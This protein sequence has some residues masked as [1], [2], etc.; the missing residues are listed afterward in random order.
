MCA[1][2]SGGVLVSHCPPDGSSLWGGRRHPVV[3]GTGSPAGWW[4]APPL[5]AAAAAAD[6]AGANS[7]AAA[8]LS[9]PPRGFFFLSFSFSLS[10]GCF[11]A[12]RSL[13]SLVG[14]CFCR[15]GHT[16]RGAE[17]A[18]LPES[19]QRRCRLAA[20]PDRRRCAHADARGGVQLPGRGGGATYVF[21][22]V[23]GCPR[24]PRWALLFRLAATRGGPTSPDWLVT[25]CWLAPRRPV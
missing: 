19:V 15:V 13:H 4:D 5:L 10:W 25:C 18:A 8:D 21:G 3:A 20:A 2:S 9:F 7:L 24:A 23:G 14:C 1:C 11:S 17:R 22:F 16:V 12:L 6:G